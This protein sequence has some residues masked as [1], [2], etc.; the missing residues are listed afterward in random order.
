LRLR[1]AFEIAH[2]PPPSSLNT[3]TADLIERL[4]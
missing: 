3:Y 4:L 2:D 1:H